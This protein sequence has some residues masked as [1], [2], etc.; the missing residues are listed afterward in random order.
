LGEGLVVIDDPESIVKCTNKVYLAE[1]LSRHEVPIPRTLVVHKDNVDAIGA[2]LGFPCVLKQPDS[3]FS[4]GVV[5]VESTEA[6]P[7]AL[8]RYL[9]ESELIIAQEFLPTTFDWRICIL[10]RR[11]LFACKYF[12]AENHW[13]IIKRDSEGRREFGKFE[14]LPVELAP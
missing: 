5:K 8:E 6:L 9:D 3:A 10:D 4:R 11:P 14:T 13:Q 1:L 12:M 7:E 2:Q